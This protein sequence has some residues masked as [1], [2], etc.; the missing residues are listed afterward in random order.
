M[1]NQ[2]SIVYTT[3][4][5]QQQAEDLAQEAIREKYAACANII[6][7][8]LSIYEWD[9][10]IEKSQEFLIIFKSITEKLDDLCS[11]LSKKHP[12]LVPAILKANLDTTDKFYSYLKQTLLTNI[13]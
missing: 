2:I 9:G 5:T 4:A 3:V 13:F 12:Y 7:G 8:A 10:K 6:P 11:W 1:Q